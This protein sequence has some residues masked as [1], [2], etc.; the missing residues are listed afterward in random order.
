[1]TPDEV[2]TVQLTWRSVLTIGDTF[3][4]I[5]YG[6]LFSLDPGL[7]PLFHGSMKE[8]GRNLTAM[9]SVAVGGLADPE[10]IALA[11][12]QL[13]RRHAA[14]GVRPEHYATFRAALVWALETCFGEALTPQARAAWLAAYDFLAA[15]MHAAAKEG[16]SRPAA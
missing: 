14:Y 13:G 10:K 12:R 4:E 5:F 1:V 7:R 3:A 11:L 15:A 9:L 2:R 6:K 8:Q 16:A